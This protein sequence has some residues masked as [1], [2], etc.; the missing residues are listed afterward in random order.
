MPH[1]VLAG[2]D[3]EQA[4]VACAL[5]GPVMV[6]AGAGTGKTRAITHRI[7]HAVL[8]G[9]RDSRS[10][11]AVTFTT[12]AA[13]EMR[14]RLDRLGVTGFAARTFHAAALRQL[15]YFWPE[16]VGGP[17]PELLD[18]KAKPVAQ[19]AA[20]CGLPTHR[21][22]VR[23]LAGEVDWAN[24]SLVIPATYADAA[25]QAGRPVLTTGATVLTHADTARVLAAYNELKSRRNLIDFE[26]V[27]LNLIAIMGKLPQVADQIRA[28]YRWF[29]VDEYQDVTPLQV[30]MLNAWLGERDDVCVVGDP[31]QTI[32]SF[33]GADPDSLATFTR[34]FA[35]VTEVRLD[36]CY[37]CSPQIVAVA[38]ALNRH[39]PGPARE[40]LLL[41]R[42]Q[43][44]AGPRPEVLTC[45]DEA[46][47]GGVIAR[48]VGALRDQGVSLREVAVLL[49]TNAATEPIEVALAEAGIPYTVRGGERF[50]ARPEVRE[51]VTRL[52]GAAA[53]DGRAA[54]DVQALEERAAAV[55]A[56]MDFAVGA[57][58]GGAAARE[59]WES[60]AALVALAADLAAH[61]VTSLAELVAELERRAAVA[62]APTADAV[63]LATLHAAK[64]LEWDHVFICGLVEGTL[65][66][67]HADTDERVAEERRLFYVGLTRARRGLLLTWPMAR[68]AGGRPR[69]RSRFLSELRGAATVGE[70]AP[71]SVGVLKRGASTA[72]K[73]ARTSQGPAK[74]RV[75]GAALVTGPERT[76]GR[77]RRCPGSADEALVDRLREWR[78]ATAK[79][80]DV[81]AFVVFTDATMQAIAELK[82]NGPAGLLEI[83]GIG[84]AKVEL[85]GSA[86]LD[87]VAGAGPAEV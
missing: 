40:Q 74:C 25:T 76:R 32:Y 28:T 44:E 4:E 36:R 46:D 24:S 65:P 82:P 34:R 20:Q 41:L 18:S 50:F 59:R 23:D 85:Y 81:P 71:E 30:A 15:R 63:T 2:L 84:P 79:S 68:S 13:G 43:S 6:L 69:V 49:R 53:A 19:A 70:Q 57:P 9:A 12:R 72:R 55:L 42:S 86:I 26:D 73:S 61:G 11:L 29:T 58:P 21:T 78:L 39:S 7:A 31:A 67:I 87:L 27:M 17:F 35:Q 48:R 38:N 51:A 10:G 45:A 56:A 37:R 1:P 77:C 64:G 80:R 60:L 8:T 62:H 83:P 22:M 75:C 52:R 47:E 14:E 5:D 66:I 54:S 3:P 16:A 33:A